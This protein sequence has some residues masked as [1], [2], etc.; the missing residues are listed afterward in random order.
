MKCSICEGTNVM[1]LG[2][3][4]FDRNNADVPIVNSTPMEYTRC[5]SCDFVSCPEM[6]GW[7]PADLGAKVYN[8]EYIKYDPD[9]VETRPKNYA[10]FFAGLPAIGPAGIRHLD[11][12]SGSGAMSK[13]LRSRRWDSAC[14]DPYSSSTRPD[15]K[16]NFIT[17][18]EVFEHSLDINETVADIKSFLEVDKGV[19]C[20]STQLADCNTNIDWWY[21]GARNGHISILSEKSMKIIATKH[22]LFFSSITPGIHLLQSKRSNYRGIFQR[23]L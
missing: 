22:S 4:P 9:Y 11:Y 8:D 18:I 17:A 20:F 7:T 14:Y 13:E 2:T 3:V 1:S 5:G 19:V 6:L 23:K 21:I 16:F 12:G 15:G 10:G